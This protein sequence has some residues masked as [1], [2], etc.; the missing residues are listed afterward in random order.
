MTKSENLTC[1]KRTTEQRPLELIY[2]NSL[3]AQRNQRLILTVCVASI[4]Q[5]IFHKLST[6]PPSPEPN[7]AIVANRGGES[8][9][10][11][12]KIASL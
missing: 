8:V 2:D 9:N 6:V 5:Y 12:D 7:C 4:M 1:N 11:G 3:H 10:N